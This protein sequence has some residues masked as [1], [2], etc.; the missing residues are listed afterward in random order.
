MFFVKTFERLNDFSKSVLQH[1]NTT[2][3]NSPF[4]Q[5]LF[6]TLANVQVVLFAANYRFAVKQLP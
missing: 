3:T 4:G 2:E 6:A 5:V 1:F